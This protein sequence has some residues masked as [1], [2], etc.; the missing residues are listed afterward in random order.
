MAFLS[1]QNIFK[2]LFK[3]DDL[4]TAINKVLYFKLVCHALKRYS[5]SF[6][7]TKNN[8]F[9]TVEK[10]TGDDE[11]YTTLL[12]EHHEVLATFD[13]SKSVEDQLIEIEILEISKILKHQSKVAA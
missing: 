11:L 12:M 13:M 2:A 10:N 4:K 9:Q 8:I 3:N 1:K 5:I 6:S 7:L